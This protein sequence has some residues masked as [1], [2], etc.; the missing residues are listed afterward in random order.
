MSYA[1]QQDLVDRFGAEELIQLTD[2]TGSGSVDPAVVNRA[3]ADADAEIDGYLAAKY[4]LPLAPVPAALGRLACDMARYYLYDD[5]VTEAVTQRY[6]DAVN[7]L[8]SV[9]NGTAKL[10]ADTGAE[11]AA[12][13]GVQ[14]VAGQKVFAREEI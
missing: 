13:G 2:R 7:F 3:L 1:T 4:T 12:A 5:R 14:F 10:G 8:K 9:A 6:K 11:P